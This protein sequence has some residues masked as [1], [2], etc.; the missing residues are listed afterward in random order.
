MDASVIAAKSLEKVQEQV[1]GAP[2]AG[3]G[4]WKTIIVL[5]ASTGLSMAFSKLLKPALRAAAEAIV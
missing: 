5:L 4:P 1:M 2:V 3:L